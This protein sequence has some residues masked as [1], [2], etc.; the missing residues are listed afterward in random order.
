VEITKAKNSEQNK[1]ENDHK[2]V[3]L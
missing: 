3:K 2:A 1:S